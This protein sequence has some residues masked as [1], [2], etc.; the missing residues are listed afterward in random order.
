M[1]FIK[2]II[3]L[4]SFLTT[5][6]PIAAA[7]GSVVPSSSDSE[8]DFTQASDDIE[9]LNTNT[10][11]PVAFKPLVLNPSEEVY[12]QVSRK[13]D[14]INPVQAA[15]FYQGGRGPNKLIVYTKD[16]GFHT[17]TNEFGTE[18]IVEG[19]T[20]TSLSGADS[21]IPQDGLV[22]SGHGIA[23]N[24][25]S[26]NITKGTKVYVDT[27]TGT[28]T[29]YTTS[30][31][32]TFEAKSKIEEAKSIINYYKASLPDYKPDKAESYIETANN[33]LQLAASTKQNSLVMQQ[34]SQEAVDAA[35]MAI[36]TA[37]P[38]ISTELRGLWIRPTEKTP[39]EIISTLER[40]KDSGFNSI[41]IETYY[42]GKTIFPSSTMNKYGFTVQNEEFA[43]FNPLE[44][45]IKEAHKRDIKVHIW[46]QSFYVGNKRPQLNPSS[47]LSV[48]PEWGNKTKQY[49]NSAGATQSVSEHNGYFLDPANC[50]VQDFL[51]DLILEIITDYK[52]DGINLDY[53]RY[54]NS[55][56]NN[57][58][59]AWGFSEYARNE[60]KELYGV[61]PLELTVSD[62]LWYDWNE[63]RRNK[64]TQFVKTIGQLG[65]E[66]HTYISTVIFPDIS[67]ALANKQQDW[68]TW[69]FNNYVDG[70]TPLFLTYDSGM[71]A[72][73]MNDVLRVKSPETELYA[74]LFVTFMGGSSEDL[75]RQIYE[76]RKMKSNGIILFDYAH[77]TPVYTSTLMAS[78]FNAGSSLFQRKNKN[79]QKKRNANRAKTRKLLNNSKNNRNNERKR[80]M[81]ILK[82]GK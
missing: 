11:V 73:M 44:I 27:V 79:V 29:V 20:V 66:N 64:I 56:S 6:V 45:W 24:W 40:I 59:S 55:T 82:R 77:T 4:L 71:L 17:G 57:D 50:E 41:F 70:F 15:Q 9:T 2:A 8:V 65:K 34:Y 26:Q 28:I 54:P 81:D 53:I 63:Y 10:N 35:N 47:I 58:M 78:A 1:R 25:I 23:K 52:P 42:H 74:G 69:S 7:Q 46:F 38:F 62:A 67:S 30:E 60:F 36:K 51:K 33:Y 13:I 16:F 5:S 37:V 61:D 19:N 12:K 49:A 22:I 68:R 76:A 32:Y 43:G 80:N 14:I 21:T 39:D 3:I 18:A 72:S 75:V 48:H 31:S